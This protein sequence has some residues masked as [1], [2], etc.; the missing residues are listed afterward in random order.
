MFEWRI[1]DW[2]DIGFTCN[3]GGKYLLNLD[4]GYVEDCDKNPF[5]WG[6]T[7][8]ES[9]DENQIKD[10][11]PLYIDWMKRQMEGYKGQLYEQLLTKIENGE[12]LVDFLIAELANIDKITSYEE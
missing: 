6:I 5:R 7:L 11:L 2:F 3:D 1:D 8:S 12:N 10:D 9:K 4:P